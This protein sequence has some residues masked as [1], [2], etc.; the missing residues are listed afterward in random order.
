[1]ITLYTTGLIIAVLL[2]PGV[3]F[4]GFF[5]IFLPLRKFQRTRTEE[6][7]FAAKVSSAPFAL[8]VILAA[9]VLFPLRFP[10]SVE[11]PGGPDLTPAWRTG[12]HSTLEERP[13]RVH[14]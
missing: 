4:L 1:M 6:F 3:I 10:V 9:L 14:F 5:S 2:V 13:M 12:L 8:T 11:R 7:L